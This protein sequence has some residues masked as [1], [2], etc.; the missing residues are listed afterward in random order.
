[1]RVRVFSD[2]WSEKG[3]A[4]LHLRRIVQWLSVRGDEV[5]WCAGRGTAPP[6]LA[7][8]R[9]R[10]LDTPVHGPVDIPALQ[11]AVRAAD[12]VV[13]QNVV[14]PTALAA[15]DDLVG[16]GRIR[17]IVQDHRAFCP[18][19]GKT[20]PGRGACRKV[21]DR[22]PCHHCLADD[23]YRKRMTD[24]TRD[25]A[26]VLRC[27]P[28]MV[29]S[30]FMKTELRRAGWSTVSVIPPWLDV[31][32]CRSDPGDRLALGGRLVRHKGVTIAME[33]W[34]RGGRP[35][36]LVVAG[37]GPER[38]HCDG[39]AMLGWLTQSDWMELLGGI[40]ALLFPAIWQEPFGI[41]CVE[42]LSRG[43]PVLVADVGG[44]REWSDAGCLRMAPGDVQALADA[45]R[46]LAGDPKAAGELG[47]SGRRMVAERFSR[48]A[49]TPRLA[50]FL[51]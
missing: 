35:L 50:G 26:Q 9:I 16:A 24:L 14:N 22:A 29:L 19:P 31:G 36:P 5:V 41:L 11:E 6:G 39:A 32:P 1:V 21:F 30:A 42:A 17:S 51:G 7:T 33:A 15:I 8:R 10:G 4:D 20:I 28:T 48:S 3:G 44:T 23:R 49:V 34:N 27:W 46:R 38:E 2:R 12:R 43:V 37:D 18:G 47:E 25:R 45:I 40:R 13:V